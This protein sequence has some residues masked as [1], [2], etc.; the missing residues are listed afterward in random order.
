MPKLL[1]KNG[2]EMAAALVNISGIIKRFM[3]DEEFNRLFKEA[4]RTGVKNRQTD[5]MEIYVDL[6]PKLFDEVHVNDTMRLLSE[7][8]GKSVKEL[9]EMNGTEL[10]EDA[11]AAWRE[12]I[13]PFFLRL[14]LTVGRKQSK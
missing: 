4:T 13:V 7:I 2:A 3:K 10:L 14:G 5:L 12:Q 1:E 6:I 11:L 8:E 9:L